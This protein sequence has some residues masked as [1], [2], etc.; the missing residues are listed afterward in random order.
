MKKHN[1]VISILFL[2]IA[3][4]A[5]AQSQPQYLSIPSSGFTPQDSEGIIGGNAGYDGND[6]GT[7]RLFDGSLRL[8]AP[9]SLPHGATVTSM[10][11]GGR[12]PNSEF[13]IIFTLRRNQPQQANVDM[14]SAMT[15]FQG[16]GFQTVSTRSITSPVVNN[17]NFNYYIVAQLDMVDVGN[18]QSCSV[19]FCRIG[20]TVDE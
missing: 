4:S 20:Y 8:F 18:C 14:A 19:G 17:A 9:V 5:L 15:T 3:S 12:A 2:V 11:C 13:R 7:A 16:T 6:T 10:R 1:L